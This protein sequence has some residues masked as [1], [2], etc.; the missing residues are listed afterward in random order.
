[1]GSGIFPLPVAR[2]FELV[3][4]LVM[5]FGHFAIGIFF[6]DRPRG[7]HVPDARE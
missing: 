7:C 3:A 6:Y 2:P 1:L 4:M 5:P